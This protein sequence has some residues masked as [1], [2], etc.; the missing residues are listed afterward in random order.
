MKEEVCGSLVVTRPLSK[1]CCLCCVPGHS[2]LRSPGKLFSISEA[3]SKVGG[4]LVGQSLTSVR[5]S[6]GYQSCAQQ[7]ISQV[8]SLRQHTPSV[9]MDKVARGN[10]PY[11][12]AGWAHHTVGPGDHQLGDRIH[13]DAISTLLKTCGYGRKV[14]AACWPL[15]R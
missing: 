12:A 5:V 10:G 4:W 1:P 8:A 11:V 13:N 7:V 2:F 14:Q 6:K 15:L 3:Q 9:R